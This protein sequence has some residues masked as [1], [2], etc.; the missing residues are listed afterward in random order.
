MLIVLFFDSAYNAEPTALLEIAIYGSTNSC[1]KV[2]NTG[3]VY[4]YL[5]LASLYLLAKPLTIFSGGPIDE[6]F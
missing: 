2:Y 1:C 6:D 4:F 5:F 3:H